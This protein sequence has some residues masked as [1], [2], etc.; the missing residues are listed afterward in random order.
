VRI[1]SK[2]GGC[3]LGMVLV[4]SMGAWADVLT[5]DGE[6]AT[7][8]SLNDSAL[9]GTAA[10]AVI[11]GVTYTGS[12]VYSLIQG[13]GFLS[14]P[15]QAKNGNLLDYL[16]INSAGGQSVVLSEGQVDPNF[17]GTTTNLQTSAPQTAPFI[18]T[19]ANGS[20]IAPRLIVPSDPTGT[21][22]GYDVTS[23]NNITVAYATVPTLTNAAL[24]NESQ[25]TVTGKQ[26]TGTTTY[27]TTTFPT[28]F[29]TETSQSDLFVSGTP[30]ASSHNFT[31][32]SIFSLLQN[33]GLIVDPTDPQSILDDYIVVTGSNFTSG[34]SFT[35]PLDYAVVYSLG[36]I[37]PDYNDF[38]SATFPL[39]ADLGTTFRST[40]PSDF[41]GGRYDSDVVNIDAEA[42][43]EP[44]SLALILSSLL[45]FAVGRGRRRS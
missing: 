15:A 24:T 25:F 34:K 8:E 40:A 1:S 11:G 17:G 2:I 43:P 27:N 44:G 41:L 38:T 12:S 23:V 5:I 20:P 39:L 18:A 32:V 4:S 7:P 10:S 26:V 31:G 3:A 30:P 9:G 28:T 21:S 14:D 35:P 42:V 16:T 19:M 6:V 13:A 36:E 29:P 45:L 22:D 33:A 37:D